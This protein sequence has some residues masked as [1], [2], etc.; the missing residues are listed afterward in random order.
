MI[1]RRSGL[2]Q[3][4]S[5]RYESP[6]DFPNQALMY[7]PKG[8]GD[9]GAPGHTRAVIQAALPVLEATGLPYASKVTTHD[10]AGLEVPVMH[11]CGHDV[12]MATWI[13]TATILAKSKDLWKG[14][15]MF[16]GQPAE[17]RSKR[18]GAA[19]HFLMQLGADA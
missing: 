16:I 11:A 5:V 3:A 19:L 2:E 7:L 18:L 13:G 15:L 17:E 1:K 9:P 14:T 4:R 10:D 8:L 12:H 6:F